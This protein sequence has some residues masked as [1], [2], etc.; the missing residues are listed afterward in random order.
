MRQNETNYKRQVQAV[1]SDLFRRMQE[2]VKAKFTTGG[3]PSIKWK[4]STAAYIDNSLIVWSMC[5]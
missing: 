4:G 3:K 2:H 5:R 1:I